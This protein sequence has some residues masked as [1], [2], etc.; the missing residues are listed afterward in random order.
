M[1]EEEKQQAQQPV[2]TPVAV[3]VETV[4]L[5]PP[6]YVVRSKM[7]L[8]VPGTAGI[9]QA[10]VGALGGASASALFIASM[11][12]NA[13]FVGAMITGALGTIFA[14]TSPIGTIASEVGMGMFSTSVTYMYFTLRNQL[15]E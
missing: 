1:A 10:V 13:R 7:G 2:I 9:A 15:I 3:P 12:G 4:V 14:A 6:P 5:T 8:N 11:S